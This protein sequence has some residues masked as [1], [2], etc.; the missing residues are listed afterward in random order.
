MTEYLIERVRFARNA[1]TVSLKEDLINAGE[2]VVRPLIKLL[3][4]L[5]SYIVTADILEVLGK[6]GNKDAFRALSTLLE[7][8]PRGNLPKRLISQSCIRGLSHIADENSIAEII[9]VLSFRDSELRYSAI[10]SLSK[11]ASIKPDYKNRIIEA[12]K[13]THYNETF[14]KPGT[15]IEDTLERLGQ[16]VQRKANWTNKPVKPMVIEPESPSVHMPPIIQP[17]RQIFPEE[18][19]TSISPMFTEHQPIPVQRGTYDNPYSFLTEDQQKE[20]L[21]KLLTSPEEEEKLDII[22][23]LGNSGNIQIIDELLTVLKSSDNQKVKNAALDAIINLAPNDL[24]LRFLILEYILDKRVIGQKPAKEA[25]ANA[26]RV[27]QIGLKR[28]DNMNKPI[29]SFLFVGPTGVGKTELAKALAEA[30]FGSELQLIRIDMSEY[31]D[32]ADK[33]KLIGSPPG[34]AGCDEGGRLTQAIHNK[35]QSVVLFDEIE[36]AHNEIFN[37]FLQVLDDGRLTDSK[38]ITVSFRDTIIIM[39]SNVGSDVIL[40]GIKHKMSVDETKELIE[41]VLKT[42][43]KPEFL[44]RLNDHIIF[45][46]LNSEELLQVLDLKLKPTANGLYSKYHLTLEVTDTA[47]NYIIE[48][49]MK[50]EFGFSPRELARVI[51]EEIIQHLSEKLLDMEIAESYQGKY[52]IPRGGKVIVDLIE[53]KLVIKIESQLHEEVSKTNG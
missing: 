36:K 39:T 18:K 44:N 50:Q 34:Y 38:G 15:L 41:D 21:E 17:V 20:I 19:K 37:L 8:V 46:P 2:P 25:L 3:P 10:E 23:N 5:N 45:K 6:I 33:N 32:M 27:A 7:D 24:K 31:T 1:L 26:L 47:K 29:G 42:H 11:I 16:S 13:T 52:V 49:T 4:G 22:N 53:N 30:L 9:K 12:L 40:E 28:A 43:F 48:N 14:E 51:D 35:P